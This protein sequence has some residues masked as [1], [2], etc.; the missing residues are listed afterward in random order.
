MTRDVEKAVLVDILPPH[1][2][3]VGTLSIMLYDPRV[4]LPPID[5]DVSKILTVLVPEGLAERR[6]EEL[7][8]GL[9]LIEQRHEV[10]ENVPYVVPP[11][12][13]AS[14]RGKLIER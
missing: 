12:A 13:N 14:E 8:T 9:A 11:Y 10:L 6:M 4:P 5:G 3:P 2:G 1:I 7:P